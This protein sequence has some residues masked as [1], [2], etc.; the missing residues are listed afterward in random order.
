MTYFPLLL[1]ISLNPH[2]AI[3]AGEVENDSTVIKNV[4]IL[5]DSHTVGD[6]GEYLHREIH[7]KKKYN[8]TSV[9]IGGAG[10]VH[11]TM[12]M[13]C[14]CCGYKIRETCWFDSIPEKQ[15]L[16]VTERNDG[17][18]NE[19]VG[20]SYKGKLS[21]MVFHLQP[22]IVIV[23]LGSNNTNAHEELVKMIWKDNPNR[24]II[25]IGPMRRANIEERLYPIDMLLKKY[26]DIKFVSSED[27]IGHDTV[28]TAHYYGKSAQKWAKK[29]MGRMEG[30]L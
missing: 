26:P 4:L 27:I 2:M 24:D 11:F 3:K 9:G 19:I 13:R 21:S 23:A 17:S 30:L 6:F 8:V 25:W 18:T 7:N 22:D 10:S 29:V 15:K 16:P 20:K 12:T 5:G 28:T 1:W 14:F